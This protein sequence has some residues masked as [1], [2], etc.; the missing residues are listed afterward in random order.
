MTDVTNTVIN[1][2]VCEPSVYRRRLAL[3]PVGCSTTPYA[4]AAADGRSELL[5][6]HLAATNGDQITAESRRAIEDRILALDPDRISDADVRHTSPPDRRRVSCSSM[7][8]SR[9]STW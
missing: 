6:A 9:V 3:A 1:R 2:I 7:A 4:P 5:A 8:V